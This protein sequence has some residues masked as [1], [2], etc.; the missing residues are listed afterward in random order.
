MDLFK[1]FFSQ[2][3]LLPNVKALHF[4]PKA[5]SKIKEQIASRP[6][7]I[8]SC[9]QVNVLYKPEKYVVQV[10]FDEFKEQ[11]NLF[12]YPV[13]LKINGKDELF[14]RGFEIEFFEEENSFFVYPQ[15]EVEA[16][17]TPRKNIVKFLINR[18]IISPNST[19]TEFLMDRNNYSRRRDLYFLNLIFDFDFVESI[20]IKSNWI[21]V[22]FRD[23]V[24][25]R[26]YEKQI[27]D[28]LVSYFES[29]SY[30]LLVHS[31]KVVPEY[32]SS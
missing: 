11:R 25:T 9:F 6:E 26:Q 32:L 27:G 29:C 24:E 10:G 21:Q 20:F 31:D 1:K 17:D 28:A 15:I 30:P 16:I 7:N 18:Y 13:P 3:S 8:K 12:Y 23:V 22:E 14:L 4:T 2:S 19:V 5:I